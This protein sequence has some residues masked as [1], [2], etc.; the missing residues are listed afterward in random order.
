MHHLDAAA[1]AIDEPFK[2]RGDVLRVV[3]CDKAL[4]EYA[5]QRR[6]TEKYPRASG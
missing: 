4:H 2:L 6:C 3:E 5:A 1:N